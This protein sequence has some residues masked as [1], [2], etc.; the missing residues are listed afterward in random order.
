MTDEEARAA[1]ARPDRGAGRGLCRPVAPARPQP[2]LRPAIYQAR[3]PAPAGRARPA[4]ARPLFRGRRG[5]ARRARRAASRERMLRP[6]P[7][8]DVGAAAG[9]GAFDGDE[10]A[11]AHIAFDPAWLRR[12]ARGAP[13]QLSIIRV[14]GDSM[15]P[16]LVDGDDILVDRGDARR[17]AARRHLRAADRGRAGGQA[18]RGQSGGADALDPAATIP[19]IPAGRDCD[20]AAVEIVGRVVWAGRRIG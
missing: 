10:R 7:R 11:E 17:A 9:A 5:A 4:P 6:V 18:A 20:P 14:D 2:R 1:L 13:D 8:L 15:A 16:T 3:Q 19:P 12:V